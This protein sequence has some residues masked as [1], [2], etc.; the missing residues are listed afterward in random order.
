M[1]DAARQTGPADA[2]T[3]PARPVRVALWDNARWIAITLVVVGHAIEVP[4]RSDLA[5]GLYLAIYSFH[6]PLFAF[7]SGRFSHG[8]AL[9][10]R[11]ARGILTHIV[12]PLV[13]F[14]CVWTLFAWWRLGVLQIDFVTPRWI[15][16]FLLS[17]ALWRLTLPLFALMRHPF[18]V[19]VMVACIAGYSPGVG[20]IA[21]TSRT[22]V[23][24]PFFV[25]GWCLNERGGLTTLLAVL[26]KWWVRC[27]AGV[28]VVVVTVLAVA[29]ADLM[30][31]LMLRK[32]FQGEWN[33]ARLGNE[34]WWAGFERA[35]VMAVS[36]VMI[37]AA[38]ALVPR[39]RTF[40][41]PWGAR[42]MNVYLL[43]L[44]PIVVATDMGLISVDRDSNATIVGLVAVAIV[45]SA[46]LSTR[47]VDVVF[48]PFTHPRARWLLRDDE[49][50]PGTGNRRSATAG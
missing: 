9:T 14:Q 26:S 50:P 39:R 48:G 33:Y 47:A 23:F 35:A 27:L 3:A 18:L 15:L 44:F 42:T 10:S 21:A 20:T 36:F 5:F 1:T 34:E 11:E 6:M 7:I 37:A 13:I 38:L 25:A 12:L 32:W 24:L 30:R 40:F 22:L 46:V 19:S 43:H 16:W 2:T 45:W 31:E 28:L 4:N 41:T 49:A 17:L 8:G 29:R